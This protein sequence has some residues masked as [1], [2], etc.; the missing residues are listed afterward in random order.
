[1]SPINRAEW[2]GSDR[3]RRSRKV[4]DESIGVGQPL[5]CLVL[6]IFKERK[7]KLKISQKNIG[8][9]KISIK[10]YL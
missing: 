8:S 3:I 2:D 10:E 9:G 7:C 6:A 1:L 4:E 5:T